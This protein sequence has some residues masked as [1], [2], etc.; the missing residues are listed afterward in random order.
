MVG[1]PT[2]YRSKEEVE[3]WKQNNDPIKRF[4][5][6]LIKEGLATDEEIG[7]LDKIAKQNVEDA[8]AFALSSPEP[9][10]EQIMEL[11]YV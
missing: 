1:D 4:T 5:Q 6:Y 2:V 7:N 8:I 3:E 10:M 11:I 9:T